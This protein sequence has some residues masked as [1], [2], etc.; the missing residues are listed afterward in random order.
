MTNFVC[1]NLVLGRVLRHFS[2]GTGFLQT[3]YILYYQLLHSRIKWPNTLVTVDRTTNMY[4]AWY[5]ELKCHHML[6]NQWSSN[7]GIQTKL[8]RALNE[9]IQCTLTQWVPCIKKQVVLRYVGNY[10]P[11]SRYL[12]IAHCAFI[13]FQEKSCPVTGL[14]SIVMNSSIIK[15]LYVFSFFEKYMPCALISYCSII[16]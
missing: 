4:W 7:A 16:R 1:R 6:D 14:C 5:W 8:Y 3:K 15:A 9:G 11:Y 12:I 10:I 13:Y 2:T